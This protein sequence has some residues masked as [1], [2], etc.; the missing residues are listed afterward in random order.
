MGMRSIVQTRYDKNSIKINRLGRNKINGT[1][2]H[3]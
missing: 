2:S 1:R 3:Q